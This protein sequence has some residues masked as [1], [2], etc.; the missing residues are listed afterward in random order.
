[1]IVKMSE[2]N[3]SQSDVSVSRG[4]SSKVKKYVH[5]INSAVSNFIP[6]KS[7]RQSYMDL[8]QICIKMTF[9][10]TAVVKSSGREIGFRGLF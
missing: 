7:K 2:K 3:C 6:E 1:M 4:C 5:I 8:Y 9:T 10:L